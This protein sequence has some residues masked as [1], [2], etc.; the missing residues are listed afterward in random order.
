ML[1]LL[2]GGGHHPVNR[3][4]HCSGILLGHIEVSLRQPRPSFIPLALKSPEKRL[5]LCCFIFCWAPGSRPLPATT[6]FVSALKFHVDFPLNLL[7][8]IA[9]AIYFP[10]KIET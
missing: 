3:V 9:C 10:S 6:N 8:Q 4:S 1:D 2:L 5:F 7:A